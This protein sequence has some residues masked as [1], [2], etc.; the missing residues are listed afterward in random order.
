VVGLAARLMGPARLRDSVKTL[1]ESRRANLARCESLGSKLVTTNFAEGPLIL[2]DAAQV[3]RV[4]LVYRPTLLAL[5]L[6]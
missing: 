4:W 1:A 3:T 5:N 2:S 6:R